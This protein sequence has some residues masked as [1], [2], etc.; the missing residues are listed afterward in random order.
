MK[1]HTM[2]FIDSTQLLPSDVLLL[3]NTDDVCLRVDVARGTRAIALRFPKWT[4][5]R[6]YSQARLLRSR[7]RFEGELWA[8]GDVVVDMLPMLQRSGFSSAQ[9][10]AGQSFDAANRALGFFEGHYQTDLLSKLPAFER[11]AS[12]SR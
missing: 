6:A 5:G 11:G 9:L 10:R 2:N 7:L 8:T 3:D 4:D 1:G 12:L